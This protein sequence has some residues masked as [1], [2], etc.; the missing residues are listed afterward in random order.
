MVP[1]EKDSRPPGV[2]ES[3]EA[4][5]GYMRIR[6]RRSGQA[7]KYQDY[8]TDEELERTRERNRLYM[9]KFRASQSMDEV[10][11]RREKG[12]MYKRLAVMKMS[13]EEAAQQR[14]QNRMY[15]QRLRASQTPEEVEKRREKGR[16]YKKL[17][18]LRQTP[19][20]AERKREQNRL[21]MRKLRASQTPEE[22]ERRKEKNR[23]YKRLSV[24]RRSS[25]EAERQ[26]EQNRLY[27][28][29]LRAAK[30]GL[31]LDAQN[32]GGNMRDRFYMKSFEEVTRENMRKT[33][34]SV[35]QEIVQSCSAQDIEQHFRIAAEAGMQDGQH[36]EEAAS[37]LMGKQHSL[38][39]DRVE[40]QLGG[41][42]TIEQVER[43]ISRQLWQKTGFWDYL[44]LLNKPQ[45][46]GK[47]LKTFE[48]CDDDRASAKNY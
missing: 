9:R 38:F 29:Q 21:Y 40:K 48:A 12:R 46:D 41:M 5:E 1:S 17:S 10:E 22:V 8:K 23:M 37:H 39:I 11:K 44:A 13:T 27:M 3:N 42:Q 20:E 34:Q 30:K 24:L 47:V 4:W 33:R 6:T 26:R 15:M 7:A 35:R 28:R 16:M 25:E 14:E 31:K 36:L 32:T 45:S 2:K 43:E 19:E 18:T